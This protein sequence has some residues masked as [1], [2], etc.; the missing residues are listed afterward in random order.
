MTI[1]PN[2]SN[3]VGNDEFF[4][5]RVINAPR[6]LVFQ[7]WTDPRHLTQW[8]GPKGFDNPVCELDLRPGGRHRI[9]MRGPDGTEYPITGEFMEVTPPSLLVMTMDCSGHPAAWHDMID[10]QRTT[11]NPAG[12]MLQTVSFE[13]LDGKTRVSIRTRA[14]TPA[15]LDA[16]K[17]MGINEGWSGSL[18]RLDALMATLQAD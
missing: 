9:T 5:S 3:S 7:A 4:I 1:A 18:D 2:F 10:P 14:A 11:A 17:K 16:M 12:I 6:E 15:I 8:W 13:D